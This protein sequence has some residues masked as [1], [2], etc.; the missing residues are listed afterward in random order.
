MLCYQF[1]TPEK[2]LDYLLTK[3]ENSYRGTAHIWLTYRQLGSP[4]KATGAHPITRRTLEGRNY[5]VSFCNDSVQVEF[6][7]CIFIDHVTGRSFPD[8]VRC[9]VVRFPSN[10]VVTC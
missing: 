1:D 3:G 6:T 2:A 10:E 9:Q 7:D 8:P 4:T 5:I